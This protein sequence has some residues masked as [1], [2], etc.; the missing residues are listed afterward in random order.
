MMT[1]GEIIELHQFAQSIGLKQS[2]FQ[3]INNHHHYDL[4]LSKRQEAITAG[5]VEVSTV[6]MLRLCT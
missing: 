6:E 4:S 1:D 2:W 5:A 3:N